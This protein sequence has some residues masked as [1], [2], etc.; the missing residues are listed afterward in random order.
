MLHVLLSY[1]LI[2]AVSTNYMRDFTEIVKPYGIRTH[3]YYIILTDHTLALGLLP[4]KTCQI[5]VSTILPRNHDGGK[6]KRK[7]D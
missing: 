2:V 6:H 4:H 3:V 1:F 7:M 5:F